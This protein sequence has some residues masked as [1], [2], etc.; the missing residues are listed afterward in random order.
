LNCEAFVY[1]GQLVADF[2]DRFFSYQ[3]CSP[4]EFVLDNTPILDSVV[5][6]IPITRVRWAIL[7][8]L[9]GWLCTYYVLLSVS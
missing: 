6:A 8:Y 9:L 7:Y 2:A 1:F 4:V 5:A 3:C